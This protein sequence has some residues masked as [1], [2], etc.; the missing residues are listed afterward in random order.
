MSVKSVVDIEINDADFQRY[1]AAFAKYQEDLKAQ[2]E[3]WSDVAAASAA[4][5]AASAEMGVAVAVTYAELHKANE[6]S[7]DLTRH[8]KQQAG[9]WSNMATNAGKFT[10]RV[11]EATRSL[12]RWGELT[13]LIS[14]ILGAGGLFGIDRLAISASEQRSR[15]FQLGGTPGEVAGARVDLARFGDPD[16]F[17]SNINTGINDIRSPQY[18]GM[19]NAGA[20]PAGRTDAADAAF[21][22]IVALKDAVDKLPKDQNTFGTMAH[23]Y[24]YD[25]LKPMEDLLKLR[26]MSREEVVTQAQRGRADT[27]K[28]EL[29]PG[30][31]RKWNDLA[32]Q[33]ER[34]AGTLKH[35]LIV[36]LTE[37]APA[38]EH[39][40]GSFLHLAELVINNPNMEKW[41]N[42]FAKAI[43]R[44]ATYLD[45]DDIKKDI[46]WLMNKTNEV[47]DNIKRVVGELPELLGGFEGAFD[48]VKK[49]F[50]ILWQTMDDMGRS[51][52]KVAHLIIDPLVNPV[53]NAW[54]W[55]KGDEDKDET[56]GGTWDQNAGDRA[57]SQNWIKR[58]W[59]KLWGT[60]EPDQE[61]P[62]ASVQQ[63]AFQRLEGQKNLPSGV[64]N[65]V[66]QTE[67]GGDVNAVSS[68]G[69][70]GPYQFMRATADQYGVANRKDFFQSVRGASD[71]LSDLLKEFHGD[72][73]KAAAGYNWGGPNVEKDVAQYGDKWREHL[74]DETK[75]YVDRVLRRTEHTQ[76]TQQPKFVPN[77]GRPS[78]VA[79]NVHNQTG[80]NSY[81]SA[82]QL[83]VG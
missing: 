52:A 24:N 80:G 10:S 53:K 14:G 69:A 4:A 3:A 29:S 50:K 17:M 27:A 20:H 82:S 61:A 42:D 67:S 31:T 44:F 2:P 39:L 66:Q 32:T 22:T 38:L 7:S 72:L 68:A 28:M 5:A 51:I 83:A 25:A 6:E 60:S 45:G 81:I 63:E 41:I 65:A 49:A 1:A 16:A 23:A 18:L 11:I 57:N 15:A 73:A 71:Y 8:T 37:L 79:I 34:V 54:H 75:N 9:F 46:A 55:L 58:Q 26:N 40:S 13:G 47:Y 77:Q 74:P 36:R 43:D 59:N 78:S 56:T 12:L 19:L 48:T 64:L 33:F 21:D 30:Q 70:V 62:A 76:M 35:D